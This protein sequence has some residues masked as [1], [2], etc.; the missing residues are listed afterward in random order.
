MKATQPLE[1]YLYGG[2]ITTA[3]DQ[4]L[5]LVSYQPSGRFSRWLV[6]CAV[7]ACILAVLVAWGYSAMLPLLFKSRQLALFVLIGAM[8]LGTIVYIAT[9]L[10]RSRSVAMSAG[11][12]VAAAL[13]FIATSQAF[14]GVRAV[15]DGAPVGIV[16]NTRWRFAQGVQASTRAGAAQ[17]TVS[18]WELAGYWGLEAILLLAAGVGAG[19]GGSHE[20]Y[21]ERCGKRPNEEV[22]K[23]TVTKVSRA[24]LRR[25]KQ[26]TTIG[27]LVAPDPEPLAARSRPVVFSATACRGCGELTVFSVTAP[28]TG[29]M[30]S[31]GG[32][33]REL[34]KDL[35]LDAEREQ[36]LLAGLDERGA[37]AVASK[38]PVA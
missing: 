18:G 6:L 32:S 15:R 13:C 3:A 33:S 36:A 27:D 2:A 38:L 4:A 5:L 7:I 25:M 11:A 22:W 23:R 9:L 21:C 29:G 35:L 19:V 1:L 31:I 12:G 16:D 24:G 8:V 10:S 37:A 30:F 14:A 28:R 26:A 34:H 17:R 20:P